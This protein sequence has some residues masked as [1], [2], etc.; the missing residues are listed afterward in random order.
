[1]PCEAVQVSVKLPWLRSGSYHGYEEV[2]RRTKIG[3]HTFL[4]EIVSDCYMTET[5]SK[6][7]YNV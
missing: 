3:K 7:T 4:C 6:H 5:T 1:M 2:L